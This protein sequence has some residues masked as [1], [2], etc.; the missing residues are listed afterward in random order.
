MQYGPLS[1]QGEYVGTWVENAVQP[2][3]PVPVGHGTPF[4]QGA[5]VTIMY[6][7]TGEHRNY[8][9]QL[10]ALDRVI[11][12]SNFFWVNSSGGSCW[13]FGAWQAGVRL[14][15]VDL[16]DNAINGGELRSCTFG[17]N[18]FLNPNAKLQFNYDLTHRSQV[19]ATP[20]GQ[21]NAFGARFAYDF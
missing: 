9:K 1:I 11:P 14:S 12:H 21:I 5:Y 19:A 8:N 2:I 4:F 10:A 20:P 17:L 6:F 3:A 18:W 15:F 7:L 13:S 16:N